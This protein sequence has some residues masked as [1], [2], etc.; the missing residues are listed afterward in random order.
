MDLTNRDKLLLTITVIL[1]TVTLANY[2]MI[3][4]MCLLS[5]A[6]S[7][8]TLVFV[9][10]LSSKVKFNKLTLALIS[11]ILFSSILS[12]T[13][14]Y[15]ALINEVLAYLALGMSL[16]VFSLA[17][18]LIVYYFIFL[19]I[20]GLNTLL[21]NTS[22]KAYY[23]I[24]ILLLIAGAVVTY[25]FTDSESL[26]LVQGVVKELNSSVISIL[27]NGKLGLYIMFTSVYSLPLILTGSIISL[28]TLLKMI[29]E[30]L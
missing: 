19:H 16:L 13:L 7:I 27:F 29:R 1:I 4:L 23:I 30:I 9:V 22:L 11:L 3:Q 26:K 20:H 5:I 10:I 28:L 18:L 14:I 15:N 2:L 21:R 8:F 24:A 17:N 12:T 25:F 6:A